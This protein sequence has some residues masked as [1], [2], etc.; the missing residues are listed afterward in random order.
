[1]QAYRFTAGVAAA[2][3][4][5]CLAVAQ[6]HDPKGAPD[7]DE[8]PDA[9]LSIKATSAAAGIGATWGSGTVNYKGKAYP[10]R[11]RGLEI[12]GVGVANID[13]S[14]EVYH[15]TNI[16]DVEGTYAAVGGAAAA[17]EAGAGHSIMR[18]DKGVVIDLAS[19]REGAQIKAGVDGIKIELAETSG[20]RSAD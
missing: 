6:A 14:G 8:K 18:N 1:M 20:K 4:A 13:A 19:E 15:L 3:L 16:A 7:K 2:T 10:V 17:G 11:I 12:G 9:K 5:L